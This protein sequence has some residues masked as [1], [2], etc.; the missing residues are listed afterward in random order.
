[1][2]VSMTFLSNFMTDIGLS[3]G[4]V[5]QTLVYLVVLGIWAGR[6]SERMKNIERRIE[7]L[8]I[9]SD[10]RDDTIQLNLEHAR[11]EL[12]E[13]RIRELKEIK[14]TDVEC[15]ANQTRRYEVLREKIEAMIDKL[16]DVGGK[17]DV[18][19]GNPKKDK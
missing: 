1:M 5:L 4:D 16:S 8:G 18:L 17:M 15:R 2:C 19:V 9:Q 3:G 14:E 7:Q 11:S 12:L 13:S 6:V 10:T